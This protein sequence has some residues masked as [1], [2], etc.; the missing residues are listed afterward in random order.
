GSRATT[1]AMVFKL[2]QSA[3]KRWRRIKHFQK[4]ELVVS[5]VKFQDGEQVADQSDRNAA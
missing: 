5:N 3:Q 2:L 1:L 4:L